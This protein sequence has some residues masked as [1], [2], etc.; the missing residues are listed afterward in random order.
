[1]EAN[2][3]HKWRCSFFIDYLLSREVD[4]QQPILVADIFP[5]CPPRVAKLV[6]FKCVTG[7]FTPDIHSWAINVA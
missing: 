4:C 6:P 5:P 2:V 7:C 1:M 3:V